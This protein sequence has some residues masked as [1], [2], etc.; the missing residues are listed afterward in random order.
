MGVKHALEIE[1]FWGISRLA[2]KPLVVFIVV[3]W[4]RIWIWKKCCRKHGFELNWEKKGLFLLKT[5]TFQWEIK[6]S[7]QKWALKIK[8]KSG[9][10]DQRELPEAFRS[11]N[12][13][14]MSLGP[15]RFYEES[16]SYPRKHSLCQNIR[17]KGI[18]QKA[19]LP[20]KTGCPRRHLPHCQIWACWPAGRCS[21]PGP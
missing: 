15:T 19:L 2:S 8:S 6:T 17:R 14:V 10:E 4:I 9:E 20:F 1:V 16:R 7:H 18:W 3:L 12:N 5:L 21:S 13:K 11:P